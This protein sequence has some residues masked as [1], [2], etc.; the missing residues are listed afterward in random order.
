MALTRFDWD[1]TKNA[2]NLAKHGLSFGEAQ[3]A[4]ADPL[5]VIAR[6]LGHS[7]REA[8]YDRFGVVGSGIATVRF[9]IRGGV[10]RIIG[11]GYWRKGKAVYEKQNHLHE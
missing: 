5:R 11:A 9:T 8:R 10:I 2:S 7:E 4:F 3:H 6:D 1:P